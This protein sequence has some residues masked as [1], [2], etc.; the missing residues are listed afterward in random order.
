GPFAAPGG[1]LTVNVASPDAMFD[2]DYTF[3]HA[4]SMRFVAEFSDTAIT[5]HWSLPGGQR[6]FRDSPHYLDLMDEWLEGEVFRMAF[7]K[8]VVE[9]EKVE[10]LVVEP[11]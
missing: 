6:H 8:A 9:A 2:H 7:D 1:E 5:S 3:V 11:R 4:A 10:T